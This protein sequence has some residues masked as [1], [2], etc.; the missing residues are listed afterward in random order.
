MN[1]VRKLMT[2]FVALS[3]LLVFPG[4]CQ[5]ED[6]NRFTQVLEGRF[7]RVFVSSNF[8]K[9]KTVFAFKHRG[10]ESF[11]TGTSEI[12]RSQDG[13]RTWNR[14]D[15]L[16]DGQYENHSD[17]WLSDMAFTN[18]GNIY[19]SGIFKDKN[20]DGEKNRVFL[21]KSH[22]YGESWE[23]VNKNTGQILL[24]IVPLGNKMI[25][26]TDNGVLI[27][28]TDSGR[29]WNKQVKALLSRTRDS[30]AVVNET[31]Y[32]V[33]A[34]NGDV[35]WT[36]DEGRDWDRG[37][38]R[39]NT[40]YGGN[41][42]LLV[43]PRSNNEPDALIAYSDTE[44]DL[45][46]TYDDGFRWKQTIKESLPEHSSECITCGTAVS[47]GAVFV[48]TPRAFVLVSEDFGQNWSSIKHGLRGQVKDI[49]AVRIDGKVAAFAATDE[50]VYRLDYHPAS[51]PQDEQEPENR[52]DEPEQP[53]S[54]DMDSEDVKFFIDSSKYI[55]G[56]QLHYMDARPFIEK[57][58][59]Y[60]PVR[61]LAFSLGIPEEGIKWNDEKK[62]VTLVNEGS[63][64]SLTIGKHI[65][66]LDGISRDISVAPIIRGDR[67][68]LPARFIVE[69][70]GYEASW[71]QTERT[72]TVTKKA[73]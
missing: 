57:D 17:F 20:E 44:G 30:L 2:C 48:G 36:K 18:G 54:E 55:V 1:L 21:Y 71:D 25:G 6:S 26:M 34:D 45:H 63:A 66:Y 46:V 60:V 8:E 49:D 10:S 16:V 53:K 11:K 39:L 4:F 22:D 29:N 24:S 64:L 68:Y 47:G 27:M 9:D 31:T 19:L 5:A 67:T 70:F 69:A 73:K 13:G 65:M 61:Y 43:L 56:E 12:Y 40:A 59:T 62:E 15:W 32:W 42:K 23:I 58:R 41:G 72:V 3:L 50:G 51:L 28:S 33:V 7:N 37:R 52:E 14:L 35:W 38:L